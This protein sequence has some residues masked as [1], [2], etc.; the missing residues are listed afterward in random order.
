MN[1][2]TI[3][4]Y[5]IGITSRQTVEMPENAKI[6]CV[7]MQDETPTLWAAVIPAAIRERRTIEIFGTGHPIDEA[8][9]EYIG[10]VQDESYVWH[11][12]ERL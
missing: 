5:P 7:Q 12:F 11:V 1:P 2:T 8:E 10:T 4:K 3:H 6:L 9:R